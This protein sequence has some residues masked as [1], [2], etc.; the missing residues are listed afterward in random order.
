MK[1]TKKTKPE[2]QPQTVAQTPGLC[3]VDD[4]DQS[5]EAVVLAAAIR[6]NQEVRARLHGLLSNFEELYRTVAAKIV[7]AATEDRF[8]DERTIV[9]ALECC[10]LSRCT[11]AGVVEPLTPQQVVDLILTADQ[12]KPGQAEAYLAV[13]Q[14]RQEEKR[15][16]EIKD[17]A[18]SLAQSLGDRPEV[19]LAEV[20]RLVGDVRKDSPF[21]DNHPAELLELNLRHSTAFAD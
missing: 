9:L 3:L 5:L 8:L 19:L 11:P 17:S 18:I 14:K 16:R 1:T 21:V 15:R 6:G 2:K 7:S 20:E 12:A 4:D 13:L 10:H